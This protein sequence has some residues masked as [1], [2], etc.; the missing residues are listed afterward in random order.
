[1]EKFFDIRSRH[2]R[3]ET[4][5]RGIHN[6]SFHVCVKEWRL[7]RFIPSQERM[8]QVGTNYARTKRSSS[9]YYFSFLFVVITLSL[10]S[11]P[12][13]RIARAMTT[14]A[15]SLRMSTST[16]TTTTTSSSSS[17]SSLR[18]VFVGSGS[19]G[20]SDPRVVDVIKRM[21]GPSARNVLYLG[22]ATY[23]L[24]NFAQRQTQHFQ[25]DYRVDKLDLV[26][27][28][29]SKEEI[30]DSIGRADI[31]VVGGG[32]TL[33]AVDRWKTLQYVIPALEAAKERGAILT[34]GS[35]GSICWFQSGHSNAMDPETYYHYRIQK[36]AIEGGSYGDESSAAGKDG[37]W[38]YIRVPGLGFLPGMVSPHHDRI[39]SNG[40]LRAYDFDRVL[41]QHPG[42]LGIGIDHW[43]ALAIDGDDYEVI[44]LEDKPGSVLTE[45]GS[46]VFSPEAKGVPGIWIKQ[47]IDGKVESTLLPRIG[48]LSSFLRE[49]ADIIEDDQAIAQ[50]RYENP[51]IMRGR[52]AVQV[53]NS[54]K[55]TERM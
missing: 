20:M 43:A 8:R 50:C 26:H 42:E 25:G 13:T 38:K 18:G 32:N 17:T 11:H 15:T 5:T 41:L 34:G 31:I 39:Q 28:S 22:T 47:V 6:F 19:D 45:N 4:Y 52:L 55:D 51:D 7:F 29:P 12:M 33:Y 49:A 44:S 36:F 14:T 21:A 53:S 35:A 10:P 37:T 16:S 40:V 48:K 24:P 27:R 46:Q 30:E 3:P 9:S 54:N 1:M 23:D 2:F